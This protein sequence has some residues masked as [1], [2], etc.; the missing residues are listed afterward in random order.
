MFKQQHSRCPSGLAIC[1]QKMYLSYQYATLL[2]FAT[3]ILAVSVDAD[4]NITGAAVSPF[5][6]PYSYGDI[7]CFEPVPGRTSPPSRIHFE[8]CIEL[9]Y[10]ILLSPDAIKST[11]WAQIYARYPH[12]N[13]YCFISL[14]YQTPLED[15]NESFPEYQIAVAAA[16]I[17]EYCIE[18]NLGGAQVVTTRAQFTAS[19]M[20]P[21]T[22]AQESIGGS[23]PVTNISVDSNSSHTLTNDTYTTT[24]T[25]N[26]L[27][28]T[29]ACYYRQPPTFPLLPIQGASCLNLFHAML[30]SPDL[31]TITTWTGLHPK[32]P[33][34]WDDCGMAVHGTRI[35]A[36]DFRLIDVVV[37]AAQVVQTCF[38]E[39]GRVFGGAMSLPDHL[40]FYVQILNSDL[41]GQ[42]LTAIE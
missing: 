39:R 3:D 30:T 25:V 2:L 40:D 9:E 35:S 27:N 31:S 17:I 1:C 28:N 21:S 19:V 10:Y 33:W 5:I 7:V 16:E 20:T 37:A 8:S 14:Y 26:N 41:L 11:N 6:Q 42:N 15:P 18:N 12:S 29:I 36:G 13:V 22:L 34:K 38:M 32:G 23:V 24:M 4:V